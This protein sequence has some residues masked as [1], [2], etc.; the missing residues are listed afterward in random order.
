MNTL[1]KIPGISLHETN[2]GVARIYSTEAMVD[3]IDSIKSSFQVF[4]I[5]KI[6]RHIF[7]SFNG[8]VCVVE[9]KRCDRLP[10]L[11]QFS[12]QIRTNEATTTYYQ[13]IS[14]L[15]LYLSVLLS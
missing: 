13:Y 9:I 7:N 8:I 2:V 11:I 15:H 10:L 1:D 5:K 3:S 14:H 4:I 12:Y 6:S